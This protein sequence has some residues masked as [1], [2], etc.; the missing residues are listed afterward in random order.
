[1]AQL[2]FREWKT[3]VP[4]LPAWRSQY[5][6][7]VVAGDIELEASVQAFLAVNNGK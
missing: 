2:I 6:Q 1:V 5:F 7:A 3:A 4:L